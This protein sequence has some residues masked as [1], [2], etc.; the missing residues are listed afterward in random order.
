MLGKNGSGKTTLIKHLNGL[1]SPLNGKIE[2]NGKSIAGKTPV[3]LAEMVGLS[4]QNPN[5]Q[6]FKSRVE[7]ELL[8]GLQM[9][10]EKTEDWLEKICRLF[11]LENLLNR[12]PFKLSE[13]EKRRVA[14][15]SILAMK[16]GIV[17]LDEPSAGLDGR[18][19]QMLADIL[20]KLT[21]EGLTTIC[22]THD[23]DFA[24]AVADRWIMLDQ[25]RIV[26]T[27]LPESF[28]QMASLIR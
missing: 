3:Q 28:D 27:G 23:M 18:S 6:F 13:G 8:L 19:K 12:S 24:R 25:G 15:A 22:V 26:A 16:P 11:Q 4:F 7:D 9:I 14:I 21:E 20:A 10:G 2:F 17:V 5:D 1:Y